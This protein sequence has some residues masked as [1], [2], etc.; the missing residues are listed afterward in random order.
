MKRKIYGAP[1]QME[2]K[3]IIKNGQ[4]SAEVHFR[5]GSIINRAGRPASYATS[6]FIEQD[7]IENSAEFKCG[8]IVL[9]H[10]LE[11]PDDAEELARKAA[12]AKADKTAVEETTT[13]VTEP[14][15][16]TETTPDTTPDA[17]NAESGSDENPTTE[18][19]SNG[20]I[21]NESGNGEES[22][23]GTEGDGV[24]TIEVGCKA[25]A[26]E[27][28]KERYPEKGYN[29]NNL[30]AN[31]AFEAACNEAGVKFIITNA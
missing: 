16:T 5:G 10:E 25:D 18:E 15:P 30:R 29:G 17:V 14:E 1:G 12:L 26:V 24:Q 2:C 8:K 28:L 27:W 31:A 4:F 23:E 7:I 21:A 11:V 13:T 3:L 20:E 6:R 9:L 19:Q 22:G